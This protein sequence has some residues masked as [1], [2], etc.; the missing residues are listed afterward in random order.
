MEKDSAEEE[1][2]V[3]SEK[4]DRL[5]AVEEEAKKE[6]VKE[7]DEARSKII[8]RGTSIAKVKTFDR[9][10]K[11][12]LYRYLGKKSRTEVTRST[13]YSLKCRYA[14]SKAFIDQL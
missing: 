2:E 3:E 6:E 7:D 8:R 9:S 14:F 5:E 1:K 12:L 13:R 11:W 4:M 10:E